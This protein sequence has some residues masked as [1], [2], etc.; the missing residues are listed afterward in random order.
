MSN[1][2]LLICDY[3]TLTMGQIVFV[4]S[5]IIE[6]T[7]VVLSVS[8]SMSTVKFSLEEGFIGHGRKFKVDNRLSVVVTNLGD[9]VA[10]FCILE[11]GHQ[12]ITI[13]CVIVS[14]AV[15]S[16]TLPHCMI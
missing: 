9:V 4:K 10:N 2:A 11:F 6:A 5:K 14:F 3:R 16:F 15:A 7:S 13:D 1:K 8:F 12:I